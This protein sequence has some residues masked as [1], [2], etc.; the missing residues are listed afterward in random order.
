MDARPRRWQIAPCSES[1]AVTLAAELDLHRTTAEVLIRRGHPTAAAARAFLDLDGPRHDP[2]LLGDMEAAC[3]RI[4]R[5][6]ARGEPICI[7]GDYDVDGIC[8]T[9]LAVTVLRELGAAVSWHLPSRFEE[10]Y[11]VGAQALERVAS[12]G[13]GLLVTVDCGVTAVAEVA[14]ARE[15]G[16]DVIVTDHHRP[17]AELPDC[18]RV[19]TRPSEYPFPELCGTGVVFKLAEA[20]FVRMGRDAAPLDRHLD[21]VGLATVADVVPLVDENRRL[22]RAGLRRMARTEKPGLRALMSAA[23]VDRA[24]VSASDLGFRLGPRINAA[25]RLGHPGDALE[26]LL[27]DDPARADELAEKLE[28]LNRRRQRV[29]Q[30]I[31]DGAV[32][33]IEEA[34]DEWRERTAYVLASSEWHEGVIG[35]VASRLVERYC[36]PVVLIAVGDGEGKGSG[37]SIPRFDLHAGLSACADHLIRFGGHRAAAGLSIDPGRIGAFADALAAH[38]DRVLEP[39]DLAASVRV[40]AILAP[41][42]ISLE[43]IDEL[44]RLEPFGL[45]NPGVT[46]LAPAATLHQVET[47]SEGRHMRASVE[48]GG[49]RCR[50]VGFRL[51]GLADGLRRCGRADIA[52]RLQRH[53]WNGAA[54]PQMLLRAVAPVAEL[55]TP[56]E[57][58]TDPPRAAGP[59]VA[60]VVDQ[61]GRGVQMATIGRLLA[62]GDD[63]LVLVADRERR[64]RMLRGVLAPARFCGGRVALAEY[65]EVEHAAAGYASIVALDPPADPDGERVLAVLAERARVHLVWGPAEIEFAR[66]VAESREPLR[67]AL[68]AV[69]RARRSGAEPH[70]PAVT[71]D[72]CLAVMAELGLDPVAPAAGKVQLEHSPTYRAALERMEQIQRYL[73]T[74][75]PLGA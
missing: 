56:A 50:A 43:L 17:G 38:A 72:G 49:F 21:L 7:H 44:G 32:A 63:V 36:R 74:V 9:A 40:D 69:W 75:E 62:G 52:F 37:R 23:R 45:G 27:T 53:E 12:A 22:V 6:I 19:C 35:I 34:G 51:G 64:Q 66:E 65:A 31:L 39:A 48:L 29:E 26:L 24:H 61:R 4:E 15:L 2:L 42:E 5:A 57:A 67:P 25:G 55:A 11:G 18:L 3:A 16:L 41:S 47:M 73:R 59:V 68:A 13:V 10:G 58:P 71:L 30:E 1:A 8:A 33:Q 14:R 46:L 60:A 28:N 70:L 54:A 20:L